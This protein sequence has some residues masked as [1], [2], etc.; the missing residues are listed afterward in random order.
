MKDLAFTS[1]FWPT[2]R[3]S[4]KNVV[5]VYEVDSLTVL[6]AQLASLAQNVEQMSAIQ[7]VEALWKES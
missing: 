3:M 7:I 5:E 1:S 6:L 2:K 4:G